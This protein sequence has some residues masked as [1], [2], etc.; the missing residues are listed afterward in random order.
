M[1][2][3]YN[4][5]CNTRER[6]S[7][8]CPLLAAWR[9]YDMKTYGFW[10]HAYVTH[11]SIF[12]FGG[13]HIQSDFLRRSN[14]SFCLF[15]PLFSSSHQ[16]SRPSVRLEDS[17]LFYYSPSKASV[18]Y[19]RLYP[20]PIA[21]STHSQFQLL[22]AFAD[23][24]LVTNTVRNQKDWKWDEISQAY[25]LSAAG[26]AMHWSSQRIILARCNCRV[27]HQPIQIEG[28]EIEVEYRA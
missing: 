28:L 3:T 19:H 23:R 27:P 6:E 5:R 21:N 22:V 2:G 11:C 7:V 8:R 15:G 12:H 10:R 20:L 16:L 26:H 18:L 25:S 4:I 1:A 17:A 14:S 13:Q 9:Y 24:P